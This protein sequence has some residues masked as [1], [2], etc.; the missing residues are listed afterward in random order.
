MIRNGYKTITTFWEDFSIADK[1]GIKAIQDTYMR[2][3]NEWKYDY[4]YLTELALVLNWKCWDYYY[5]GNNG[6][7]M[8]YSTLYYEVNDFARENL[9]GDEFEYFFRIT[10]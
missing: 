4:K 2:A 8:L 10:D 7:S 3:F 1:F 9:I 6:Y 5:E